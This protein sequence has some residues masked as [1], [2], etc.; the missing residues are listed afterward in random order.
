MGRPPAEGPSP[1]SDSLK[2][3]S[4]SAGGRYIY[5]TRAC[6]HRMHAWC[7]G[8]NRFVTCSPCL[9]P[10]GSMAGRSRTSRGRRETECMVIG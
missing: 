8:L 6:V 3:V 5:R 10:A 7:W 2:T 1:I 9:Y 4:K